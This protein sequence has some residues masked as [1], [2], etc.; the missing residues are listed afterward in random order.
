MWANGTNWKLKGINKISKHQ[1]IKDN[2][3]AKETPCRICVAKKFHNNNYL[4]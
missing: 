4:Y 1:E 2:E 3:V